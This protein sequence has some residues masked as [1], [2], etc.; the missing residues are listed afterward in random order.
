MEP[1]KLSDNIIQQ[2]AAGEVIDR[3]VSIVKELVENAI[4]ANAKNITIHIKDGGNKLISVEDDGSGIQKKYLQKII[5][6]HVTSKLTNDLFAISTLGF[7]GEALTSISMAGNLEIISRTDKEHAWSLTAF[8]GKAINLKPSSGKK[9]TTVKLTNLF[10]HI[11]ARAKFLS[12]KSHETS[13]IRDMIRHIC[14]SKPEI[15]FTLIVDGK[16]QINTSTPLKENKKEL[17][18]E[19]LKQILGEDT[20]QDGVLFEKNIENI[21]IFGFTT[22]PIRARN[23]NDHQTIVINGR[24]IKDQTILNALKKAY[25]DMLSLRKH[26]ISVLYINVPNKQLDINVHPKKLEVRFQHPDKVRKIIT[27]TI[28]EALGN[29]TFANNIYS[30][31]KLIDLSTTNGLEKDLPGPLGTPV[32][33]ILGGYILSERP[34]GVLLIDQH[35]A[36]ERILYEKFKAVIANKGVESIP[37]AQPIMMSC[38]SEK[39]K[40]MQDYIDPLKKL[41]LEIRI[42]DTTT[43]FI[44][45]IPSLLPQNINFTKMVEDIL[46]LIEQSDHEDILYLIEDE[47]LPILAEHGCK[48]AIKMGDELTPEEMNTLLR[49]MEKTPRA[50]QCNHGRP[51]FIS[52]TKEDMEKLFDRR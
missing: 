41:G 49:E 38:D 13:L 46:D 47:I 4:D 3:P 2:I 45:A 39:I 43:L 14:L 33:Q 34:E 31:N 36:H 37:L 8:N 16:K 50:G 23:R 25:R 5:E 11:P 22:R 48:H 29:E 26:P 6:K 10:A 35:A 27:E 15:S 40:L 17:F 24:I 19:R 20:L 9:G 21:N 1:Q 44:E 51:T 42:F 18:K 30:A 28:S 7:R 32:K 12:S 52:L